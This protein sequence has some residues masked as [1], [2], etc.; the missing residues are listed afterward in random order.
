M[1]TY[2]AM[3]AVVVC[4]VCEQ[5]GWIVVHF[6]CWGAKNVCEVGL[7]GHLFVVFLL[8]L[9]FFI[10][11]NVYLISIDLYFNFGL[12]SRYYWLTH[13]MYDSDYVSFIFLMVTKFCAAIKSRFACV[14]CSF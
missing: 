3:V 7:L 8:L 9:T 2:F 12:F 11:Y 10:Y 6:Y 4:G 5:V 14:L 13:F 1:A